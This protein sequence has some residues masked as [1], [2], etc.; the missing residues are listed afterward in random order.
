MRKVGDLDDL[1]AASTIVQLCKEEEEEPRW[2]GSVPGRQMVPRDRFT[3]HQ[4]LHADYFCDDPV[5]KEDVFRRR[6]VFIHPLYSNVCIDGN[7][8]HEVCFNFAGSE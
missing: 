7:K 3:G 5:Y 1:L 2:G 8:S 6:L 4:R